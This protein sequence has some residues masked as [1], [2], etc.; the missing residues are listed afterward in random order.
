VIGVSALSPVENGKEWLYAWERS[1]KRKEGKRGVWRDQR[2]D[3]KR[4]ETIG[5]QPVEVLGIVGARYKVE[6]G[7]KWIQCVSAACPAHIGMKVGE[8][9]RSTDRERRVLQSTEASYNR[10]QENPISAWKRWCSHGTTSR[11]SGT[12]GVHVDLGVEVAGVLLLHLLVLPLL[13]SISG[14]GGLCCESAQTS[15]GGETGRHKQV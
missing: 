5:G 11:G 10:K 4:R 3:W 13:G 2:V 6:G 15:G 8:E 7:C 14:D 12:H 9:A 1:W